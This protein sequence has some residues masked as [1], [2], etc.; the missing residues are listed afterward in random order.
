MIAF[1]DEVG[2]IGRFIVPPSVAGIGGVGPSS[3]RYRSRKGGISGEF[4]QK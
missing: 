4:L 3:I 1:G 2:G